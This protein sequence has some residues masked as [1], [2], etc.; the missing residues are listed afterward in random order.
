MNWN[1]YCKFSQS[2]REYEVLLQPQAISCAF[3]NDPV[4]PD[5][6]S[7]VA[8]VATTLFISQYTEWMYCCNLKWYSQIKSFTFSQSWTCTCCS[9]FSQY[10]GIS[11]TAVLPRYMAIVAAT[12][13]NWLTHCRPFHNHTQSISLNGHPQCC[14]WQFCNSHGNRKCI[15]STTLVSN[16][17]SKCESSLQLLQHPLISML[18]PQSFQQNSLNKNLHWFSV[19][20]GFQSMNNIYW[21]ESNFPTQSV[22]KVF[23]GKLV[24]KAAAPL[25]TEQKPANLEE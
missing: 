10:P 4:L 19:P 24:V 6:I 23:W 17:L 5:N 7:T 18:Q 9:K 2:I 1:C 25:H 21:H 11:T 16:F 14:R 13:A 15:V 8:L 3:S 22:P 12:S 20:N